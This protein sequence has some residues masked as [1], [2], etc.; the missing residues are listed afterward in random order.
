VLYHVRFWTAILQK[1]NPGPLSIFAGDQTLEISQQPVSAQVPCGILSDHK[2]LL[3]ALDT[4]AQIL[5]EEEDEMVDDVLAGD[6]DTINEVAEKE[7]ED[8]GVED[9]P[10]TEDDEAP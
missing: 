9:G 8:G 3:N 7:A 1:S 5:A 4:E 2:D 10:W 6:P